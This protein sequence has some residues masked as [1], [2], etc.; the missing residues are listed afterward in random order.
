MTEVWLSV[1]GF[2]GYEVSNNGRVRRGSRMLRLRRL[3]PYLA[4]NLRHDGVI[5]T[6]RVHQLVA[7]AF[8]G[9]RPPG[10]ECLHGPLGALVNTPEN[11][12]W[13]NRRQNVHDMRRD[14]TMA[15]VTKNPAKLYPERLP[16]GDDHWSRKMHGK[17][18]RASRDGSIC[19]GKGAH[20]DR[21]G[22][23]THPERVA[24]GERCGSAKLSDAQAREIL[25]SSAPASDVAAQYG[26]S[27]HHVRRIR[28]GISRQHLVAS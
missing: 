5:K 3:G 7:E 26:I 25:E 19:P 28:R 17:S 14:G 4:V 18:S 12:S 9:P 27:A 24:R 23:R 8:H 6:R 1:P 21:N 20:G 15:F 22:A 13:G 2:S 16:H 10:M 11:L